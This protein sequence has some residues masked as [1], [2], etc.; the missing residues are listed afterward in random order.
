MRFDFQTLECSHLGYAALQNIFHN[1]ISNDLKVLHFSIKQFISAKPSKLLTYLVKLKHDKSDDGIIVIMLWWELHLE[2]LVFFISAVFLTVHKWNY[3]RFQE[4]E[5]LAQ[6]TAFVQYRVEIWSSIS[7][8]C[9][10]TQQ[11]ISMRY[12]GKVLTEH[13]L[14]N[15]VLLSWKCK[16]Y[17][18]SC[19]FINQNLH[20]GISHSTFCRQESKNAN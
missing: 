20:E 18:Y 11:E 5:V 12:L 14:Q 19:I 6:S 8:L 2:K 16:C 3:K 13:D 7:C 10:K 4:K 15:W 9:G 1:E 17:F